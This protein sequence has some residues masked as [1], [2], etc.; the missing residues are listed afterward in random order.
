MDQKSTALLTLGLGGALVLFGGG[1]N[2]LAAGTTSSSLA[3]LAGIGTI[4]LVLGCLFIIVGLA[5]LVASNA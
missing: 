1:V 4:C 3:M 5:M 2:L